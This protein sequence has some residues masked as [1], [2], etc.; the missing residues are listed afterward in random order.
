[1]NFLFAFVI[2]SSLIDACV[3]VG[4]CDEFL[5]IVVVVVVVV[6][7][8]V[9]LFGGTVGFVPVEVIRD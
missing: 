5:P 4:G 3:F 9:F 1:M 7:G 2:V 8:P 6:A